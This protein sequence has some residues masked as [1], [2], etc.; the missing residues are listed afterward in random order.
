M[1][2]SHPF[3]PAATPD[4]MSGSQ[5]PRSLAPRGGVLEKFTLCQERGSQFTPAKQHGEAHTNRSIANLQLDPNLSTIQWV[6]LTFDID[7]ICLCFLNW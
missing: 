7:L 5:Y 3:P 1:M 2:A 4:L 6:R